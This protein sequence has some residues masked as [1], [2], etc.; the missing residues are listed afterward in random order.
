[1]LLIQDFTG[2]IAG[3]GRRD[4]IHRVR[5]VNGNQSVTMLRAKGT[6][7]A[8]AISDIDVLLNSFLGL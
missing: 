6:S 7:Y 8:R 4:A 3:S 1:M 5:Q 2:Q